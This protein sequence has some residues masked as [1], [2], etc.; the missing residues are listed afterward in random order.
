VHAGRASVF[1]RA[2][3]DH[4]QGTLQQDLVLRIGLLGQPGAA[5]Q[6][7]ISFVL[8]G[9]FWTLLILFLTGWDYYHA[10]TSALNSARTAA[11]HSY[12]KDLTFRK[13]ATG[14]GGVYAP[15][16]PANPPNANLAHV[17]ERDL[18]T[19]SGRPLTLIN[20][21]YMLRQIHDLADETFGTRAHITSL[22]PIRPGNAPDTWE[23]ET[24]EAFERGATERSNLETID[25]TTY[26]RLMRV[27]ATR[28][29]TGSGSMIAAAF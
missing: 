28:T 13:W 17:P 2:V 7:A 16:S 6:S 10:R 5:G 18:T 8:V 9:I 15:V 26:L 19:P 25:D 23:A 14:H 3:P 24:L 22:R 1:A 20:P 27:C 21:A 11:R 12:A 4:G 29:D